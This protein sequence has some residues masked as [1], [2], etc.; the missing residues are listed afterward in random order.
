MDTKKLQKNIIGTMKWYIRYK[1]SVKYHQTQI[2]GISISK[3]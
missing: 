3:Y 1:Y 2:V